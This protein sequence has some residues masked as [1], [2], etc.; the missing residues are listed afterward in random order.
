MG[1]KITIWDI[2]FP[3][4]NSVKFLDARRQLLFILLLLLLGYAEMQGVEADNVWEMWAV[5]AEVIGS[6][7]SS[8]AT[9]ESSPV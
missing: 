9:C 5:E 7:A 4:K 6:V 1:Y 2:K 8:S 3:E